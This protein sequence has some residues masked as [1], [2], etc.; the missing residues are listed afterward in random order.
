MPQ[1]LDAVLVDRAL[2]ANKSPSG[3][4]SRAEARCD[5][6]ERRAEKNS[7]P[8]CRRPRS[9]ISRGLNCSPSAQCT[10][11]HTKP[12]FLLAADHFQLDS[13]FAPDAVHQAPV[14]AHFARRGG[15]HGA[16]GQSPGY[17]SMR[18]RKWRK[19]RA[20]H[21]DR[22]IVEQ[23]AGESVVAQ[24]HGGAL[25]L[26]DLDLM[27]RSGARDHQADGVRSRVDRRQLDGGGHS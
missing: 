12:R 6:P 15:G 14:V 21:E 25:V 4:S 11:E 9:N 13:G 16:V 10:A 22:F 18:S 5:V 1:P 23:A 26:Q 24:P 8:G 2:D 17:W 7:A 27:R 20:A 19:T 3:E